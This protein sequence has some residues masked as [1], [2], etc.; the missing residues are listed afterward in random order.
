MTVA[1][2][3]AL[4]IDE[5]AK[6]HPAAE[7][8]IVYA[9]L[10]ASEPIPLFLF[11]DGRERFSEPF[12]SDLTGEGL[13]E[14]VAAL[15]AFALADRETISDERDPSIATDCVRLHRL[16]RQVAGARRKGAALDNTQV[17]L[18]EALTLF[19]PIDVY[20][21]ANSWQRI[22][23]LDALARAFVND[24]SPSAMSDERTRILL[25]RLASYQQGALAAVAEARPLLERAALITE[26]VLGSEH[27]DTAASLHNLALVLERLG[28]FSG[29][30]RHCE[31]ALAIAENVLGPEHIDT[32][33]NL[34]NLARV[35][36]A[37]GKFEEANHHLERALAIRQR[38]LGSDHPD[39]AISLNNLGMLRQVQD[40][41]LGAQS[42]FERA[43]AITL[44]AHAANPLF[45][46]AGLHNLGAVLF[47]Q[48]NFENAYPHFKQA[49]TIRE[50]VLG[51]S[52]PSTR[53]TAE[54]M[55]DTLDE[56]GRADEAKALREKY[57]TN[58]QNIQ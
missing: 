49:L 53:S 52:H 40:D 15:R 26:K 18:V 51:I 42:Y 35:L 17:E 2:T 43:L 36:R 41:L 44:K 24:D 8:L 14:A 32:A 28:D 4:A 48:Y 9:A 39:I 10:L 47:L 58:D 1:K 54:F 13:D 6:L 22:R 16:V 20:N 46:A 23:R 31:R 38:A 21:N 7:P 11:A 34:D 27:P 30:Q 25:S 29:A 45:V 50:K 57:G 56:L 33:Y 5:A 55:A 37:L 19:F 12:A 3:F